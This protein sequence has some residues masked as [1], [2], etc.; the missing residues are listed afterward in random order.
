MRPERRWTPTST[1]AMCVLKEQSPL[2]GWCQKHRTNTYVQHNLYTLS[3]EIMTF[4]TKDKT[5]AVKE[6]GHQYYFLV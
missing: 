4:R 6:A 5:G 3:I 2:C 1:L